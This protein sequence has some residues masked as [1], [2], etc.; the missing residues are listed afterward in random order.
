MG[1]TFDLE[2]TDGVIDERIIQN[3]IL[4]FTAWSKKQTVNSR[5]ILRGQRLNCWRPTGNI[6]LITEKKQL[7]ELAEA[8]QEKE[9]FKILFTTMNILRMQILQL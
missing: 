3:A 2:I 7:E 6:A 1:H 9:N 8:L 4:V 5:D